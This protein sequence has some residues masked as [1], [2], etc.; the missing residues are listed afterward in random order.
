[1]DARDPP[2]FRLWP[3]FFRT[4]CFGM[5]LMGT[6]VAAAGAIAVAILY[7][8]HTVAGFSLGTGLLFIAGCAT[9]S[10]AGFR[11]FKLRSRLNVEA[12]ISKTADDREKLE[13][14]V[15]R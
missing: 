4:L 6:V 13:Q 5:L 14:W 3:L 10:V 1:M 11:G 2:L 8:S 15:N 9:F 12:E 7:T